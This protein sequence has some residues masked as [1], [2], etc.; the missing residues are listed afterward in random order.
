MLTK[1]LFWLHVVQNPLFDVEIVHQN[2]FV[3][4]HSQMDSDKDFGII[5]KAK[6]NFPHIYVPND[7]VNVVKKA[8][9]E[10]TLCS[11]KATTIRFEEC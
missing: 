6:Q 1:S 7:W 4:G 3:S 9:T 5:E 11:D 10:E 2:Y 8:K